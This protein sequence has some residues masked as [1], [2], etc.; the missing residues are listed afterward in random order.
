MSQQLDISSS[1]G[2]AARGRQYVKKTSKFVEHFFL[3]KVVKIVREAMF[4][5]RD[6]LDL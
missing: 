6:L 3:V 1:D 2:F 4:A 5:D